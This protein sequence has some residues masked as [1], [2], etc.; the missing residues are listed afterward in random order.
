MGWTT[1]CGDCGRHGPE[2]ETS[3]EA[4]QVAFD[5]GWSIGGKQTNGNRAEDYCPSCRFIHDRV[6]CN[7]KSGRDQCISD[8]RYRLARAENFYTREE[9]SH[10]LIALGIDPLQVLEKM[11]KRIKDS[12]EWWACGKHLPVFA[13]DM[14]NAT[15]EPVL[16]VRV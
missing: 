8:S 7:H 3:P 13:R 12:S 10:A 2:A 14:L 9:V 6:Q 15:P 11:G 4:K 1:V 16:L 5:A